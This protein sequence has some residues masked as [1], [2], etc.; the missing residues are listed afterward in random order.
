MEI[1]KYKYTISVEFE[2]VDDLAAREKAKSLE[3]MFFCESNQSPMKEAE[4]KFQKIF[5]NK[6]PQKLE[7]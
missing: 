7:L 4:R 1:N 2:A 3:K 6:P 5:S